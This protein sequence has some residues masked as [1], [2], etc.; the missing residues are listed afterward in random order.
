MAE[1]GMDDRMIKR[2]RGDHRSMTKTERKKPD[3]CRLAQ[4]PHRGRRRA[5]M[6]PRST[7]C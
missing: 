2:Q 6:S 1:A 5:S 4:A 3:S 7:A